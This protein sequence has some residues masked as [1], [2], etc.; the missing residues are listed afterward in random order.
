MDNDSVRRRI[1]ADFPDLKQERIS[2]LGEG[3]GNRAFLLNDELVFRF[4]KTPAHRA[5]L[6]RELPI[7]EV[8]SQYSPLP[9][10]RPEFVA[11]DYSY[12][13]YR[14][15]PGRQLIGERAGF[16]GWFMFARA[17]GEFLAAI[18]DIPSE[19]F[20][21]LPPLEQGTP[22]DCLAGAQS[23]YEK[24]ADVVPTSHRRAIEAFLRREPPQ[25]SRRQVFCHNDLGI[26]H[27]IVDRNVVSGVIDWGDAGFGDP[28]YDFGLVY[29]DCGI[30]VMSR[31]FETY[32]A[33]CGGVDEG[34]V[35]RAMFYGKCASLEDIEYGITNRKKEYFDKGLASLAWLFP[36]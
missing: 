19:K 4:A 32:R 14:R 27:V 1:A 21:G 13:G 2:Y 26:E 36:G 6:R 30:D 9:T 10:P 24:V 3:Y 35:E 11:Q 5:E 23:D 22:R 31:T 7:L 33:S 29:R 34:L 28:A 18:N 12:V 20:D 16:S 8:V 25:T 15:I 17:I